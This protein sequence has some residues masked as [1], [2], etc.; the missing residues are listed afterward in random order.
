MR[1][2]KEKDNQDATTAQSY[3]WGK[4]GTVSAEAVPI[5]ADKMK[6]RMG[7]EFFPANGREVK[8]EGNPKE[9]SRYAVNVNFSGVD[10]M[11]HTGF[12]VWLIIFVLY[13]AAPTWTIT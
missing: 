2:E 7:R 13:L 9:D 4:G 8:E 1:S 12:N 11:S 10:P 5:H 3:K 6:L